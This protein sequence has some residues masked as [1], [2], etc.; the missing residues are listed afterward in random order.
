MLGGTHAKLALE[1]VLGI[2]SRMRM[3]YSRVAADKA[4]TADLESVLMVLLG[5]A[6]VV[7]LYRRFTWAQRS[8]EL[9]AARE[10]AQSEAAF[11]NPRAERV[12]RHNCHRR[13]GSY[14]LS[15]PIAAKSAG[16]LSR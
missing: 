12:G 15:E 3:V 2:E 8:G 9:Q 4:R 13:A 16:F 5:V 6:T 11:S 10:R 7:F 1:R 14:Q